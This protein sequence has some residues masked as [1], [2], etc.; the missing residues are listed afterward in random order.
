MLVLYGMSVLQVH[1]FSFAD[2]SSSLI[3][4]VYILSELR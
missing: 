2:D 4:D 1:L 3:L